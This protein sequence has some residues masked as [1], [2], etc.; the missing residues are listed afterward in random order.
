MTAGRR[1]CQF[2]TLMSQADTTNKSSE[3][4]SSLR[5]SIVTF[6]FQCRSCGQQRGLLVLDLG[7]QPLANNLLREEDLSKSEPKF[8]LRLAVY[9]FPVL[10]ATNV[11]LLI[12]NRFQ[13]LVA[14]DFLYVAFFLAVISIYLARTYKDVVHRPISVVDW[15]RSSFSYRDSARPPSPAP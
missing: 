9:A 4:D 3:D 12:A 5:Q 10:L 8:P 13:W 11:S 14:M 6:P 15:K 2:A 7:V 1:R